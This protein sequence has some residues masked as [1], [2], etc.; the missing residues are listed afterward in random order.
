MTGKGTG[1]ILHTLSWTGKVERAGVYHIAIPN[2]G[3]PG[4]EPKQLGD[5]TASHPDLA[6]SSQGRIAAVWDSRESSSVCGSVSSD[7]GRNWGEPKRLSSINTPSTHPRVICTGKDFR[8]FWTEETAEGA[9][10]WETAVLP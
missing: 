9:M 10:V 6:A 7:A 5:S 4:S 2:G 1:S 3:Q 8:V